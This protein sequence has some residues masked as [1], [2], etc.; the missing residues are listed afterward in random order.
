MCG[1][2]GCIGKGAI[3]LAMEGLKK[4]EYR[5]YDSAGIAFI[6]NNKNNKNYLKNREKYQKNIKFINKNLICVKEKGEINLLDNILNNLNFNSNIAIAHTRWATHGQANIENAHPHL[7]NDG[8]W[9]V[10]HNGIIENYLALKKEIGHD[11]F[12]SS[13]DSEVVAHLLQIYYNG[14]AVA[15]LCE[16]CKKIE[17]SFALAVIFEGEEESIFVARKNSPAVVGFDGQ[18]GVVCSDIGSMPKLENVFVLEEESVCKLKKDEAVFFDFEMNK[19]E[20][21]TVQIDEEFLSTEKGAFPHYMLKEIAEIPQSIEKTGFIYRNFVNFS[22]SLAPQEFKGFNSFLIIGCGTAYHAGLVGQMTIEKECK[23]RC[24]CLLASELGNREFLY[25]SDTLAIFVSQ[26]GETAD[27]LKAVMLC[28]EKGLKTMAVTNVKN[29]SITRLCDYVLFTAAGKELA[30]AST[31]A[32]NCQVALLS[33]FSAYIAQLNGKKNSVEKRYEEILKISKLIENLEI[34][35]FA[36]QIANDI[37]ES[38]SLYMIG[39]GAD[40]LLAM[41]GALKL[42]EIS[43]IHCEA[44][45]AGELK[46]GTL[47][48]IEENVFVFAFANDKKNLGKL[49]SNAKEVVSRK[50]KVIFV[51]P[52]ETDEEFYCKI[53]AEE[54]E[55][56]FIPLYNVVLMQK[57]AYYTAIL[58]GRNPDKPRGLAKSVTVE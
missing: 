23:L 26:S 38:Q 11:L 45:P 39:R 17:G 57:I 35:E 53:Q 52:Y 7:S 21:T 37:K 19:K 4:L 50:G 20:L 30:V 41:E 31:K 6:N 27:T 36:K 14:D 42:K 43:Y 1:I 49:I 51:S 28:K 47:S 48:L 44:Y 18:C 32:Y 34:D 29:S 9:A 25:K 2:Y 13:T 10:V 8:K 22:T 40:Y 55:E 15:T 54:V 5:G 16:V 33:L 56:I 46:H 24:D 58:L 12:Q 3:N